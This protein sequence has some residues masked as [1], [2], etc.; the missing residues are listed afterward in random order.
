MAINLVPFI[1]DEHDE[2]NACAY[3]V[4]GDEAATCP[5]AG[6][7]SNLVC[8]IAEWANDDQEHY[9]VEGTGKVAEE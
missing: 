4:Y 8:L 7:P 1:P 5:V 2:D 6:S 3:C 9:F